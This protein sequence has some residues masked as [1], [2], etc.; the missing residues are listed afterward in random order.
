VGAGR[1][2]GTDGI[3]GKAGSHLTAELAFSATGRS[4]TRWVRAGPDRPQSA[5]RR[6]RARPRLSSPMLAA[7]AVGGRPPPVSMY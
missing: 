1:L 6:Y 4:A 5:L 7:A 2:F 3:R